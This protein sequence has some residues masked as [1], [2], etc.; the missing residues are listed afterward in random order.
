[1]RF[2]GTGCGMGRMSAMVVDEKDGRID[3]RNGETRAE[4]LFGKERV[5]VQAG[6]VVQQRWRRKSRGGGDFSARGYG[7]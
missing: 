6:F 5:I 7:S 4:K 2:V 1:M 3:R